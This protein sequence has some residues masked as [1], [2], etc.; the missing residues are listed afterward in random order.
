MKTVTIAELIGNEALGN[1]IAADLTGT[2][3]V[4]VDNN[5]GA[6][7]IHAINFA[8]LAEESMDVALM[9]A[10]GALPLSQVVAY[11]AP[12]TWF[13][14]TNLKEAV[15]WGDDPDSVHT[16]FTIVNSLDIELG[17]KKL[18]KYLNL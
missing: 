11:R 17:K 2:H 16:F 8:E 3:E 18:V 10:V 12:E 1:E 4:V 7:V 15:S 5:D 6:Y 14:A 13:T 9:L